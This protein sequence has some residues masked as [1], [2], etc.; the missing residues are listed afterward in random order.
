M[1]RNDIF[2][3]ALYTY[4]NRILL[5]Y[6]FRSSRAYNLD[7]FCGFSQFGL[8]LCK[9]RGQFVD[10]G[11]RSQVAII[12]SLED[13]SA[14]CHANDIAFNK[15]ILNRCKVPF[16]SLR[17]SKIVCKNYSEKL[18]S[19][20]IIQKWNVRNFSNLFP[21]FINIV[22]RKNGGIIHAVYGNRITILFIFILFI[23]KIVFY[24]F[25]NNRFNLGLLVSRVC[26]SFCDEA[27]KKNLMN[28]I[29]A[30]NYALSCIQSMSAINFIWIHI[31]YS[32]YRHKLS[33]TYFVL[34]Y[35]GI[36]CSS[37]FFPRSL[38]AFLNK[39]LWP[40]EDQIMVP[41][42]LA[43]QQVTLQQLHVNWLQLRMHPILNAAPAPLVSLRRL[44]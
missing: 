23:F 44:R 42:I 9:R 7:F 34:K 25:A 33:L 13:L 5:I 20:I 41:P 35:T 24:N 21:K 10:F 28:F 36:F 4:R 32:V 1:E 43:F 27:L 12:E 39:N 30:F 6:K 11:L 40:T 17:L 37:H 3:G 15:T 16:S 29:L 14:C 8:D 38:I 18:R 26:I 19:K 2:F 22:S 31:K